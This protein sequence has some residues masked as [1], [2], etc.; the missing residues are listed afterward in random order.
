MSKYYTPTIDE[1]YVGFEC[2]IRDITFDINTSIDPTL[3]IKSL[4]DRILYWRKTI[5]DERDVLY[6]SLS[7]KHESIRVKYLDK[8]DIEELG[9]TFGYEEGNGVL[10]GTWKNNPDIHISWDGDSVD[11]NRI[12]TLDWWIETGIPNHAY[13]KN[14]LSYN[15]YHKSYFKG[16]I[17]NKSELKVLL[18][19]LGIL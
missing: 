19:Q 10:Y 6:P 16:I 5:C 15:H 4:P 11:P 1:I 2:E 3:I 9:F 12:F 17:K 7:I 13:K 8:E 18:K 14:E